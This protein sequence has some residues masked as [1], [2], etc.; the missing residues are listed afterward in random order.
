[1]SVIPV[2]RVVS[3]ND[4][5]FPTLNT[6]AFDVLKKASHPF[7]FP[8]FELTVTAANKVLAIPA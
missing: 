8:V 2:L 4:E 6:K 5:P 3:A 1:M 7:R